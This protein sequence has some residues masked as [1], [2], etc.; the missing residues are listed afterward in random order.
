MNFI[1]FRDLKLELM[2]YNHKRKQNKMDPLAKQ[3]LIVFFFK[4]KI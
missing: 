4:I 3:H 2:A 1:I